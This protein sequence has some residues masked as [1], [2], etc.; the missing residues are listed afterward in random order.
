[1]K[2]FLYIC[3]IIT[4]QCILYISNN[5][6]SVTMNFSNILKFDAPIYLS[7]RTR[8]VA[9]IIAV[10]I[11]AV[12][13]ILTETYRPYIYANNIFDFHLADSLTNLL[14]VPACVCASI[15]F[16]KKLDS[17]AVSYVAGTCLGLI[18]YEFIGFTFDYYDM[19]ATLISGVPTAIV[20]SYVIK[21]LQA[22]AQFPHRIY[23]SDGAVS[24]ARKEDTK[25]I[26]EDGQVFWIYE[27]Y[28][29]NLYEGP[30]Y[31][32]DDEK[33]YILDGTNLRDGSRFIEVERI[34]D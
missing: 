32:G 3:C 25:Y 4:Q 16:S 10:S 17:K 27:Q 9:I 34:Y 30:V 23:H 7:K 12:S 1:M 21:K 14:A 31:R 15:S 28:Q 2:L 11:A 8:V 20:L 6:M 29:S 22:D 13:W 19:L 26:D 24:K 5:S 18:L 33:V